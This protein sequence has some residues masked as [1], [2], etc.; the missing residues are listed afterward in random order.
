MISKLAA[1]IQSVIIFIIISLPI[2]YRITNRILG[3]IVGKLADSSGCPTGLGIF[4]HSLVFGVI[5]YALMVIH[6]R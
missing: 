4:I 5:I 6:I 3:N 2:T 1:T